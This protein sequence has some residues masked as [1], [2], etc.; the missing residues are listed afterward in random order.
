MAG[1]REDWEGKMQASLGRGLLL[2]PPHRAQPTSGPRRALP[3]PSCSSA[4]Q[5]SQDWSQVYCDLLPQGETAVENSMGAESKL[6]A[7]ATGKNQSR[8]CLPVER[9]IGLHW[10]MLLCPHIR[11]PGRSG[12]TVGALRS[13]QMSALKT[14]SLMPGLLRSGLGLPGRTLKQMF[15]Q[16][17]G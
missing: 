10:G 2:L 4:L 6:S 16:T 9:A 11:A 5:K 3:S 7:A 8:G 17:D 12:H 1:W 14:K 13:S 15:R